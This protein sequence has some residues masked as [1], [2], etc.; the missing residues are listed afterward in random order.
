MSPDQP[1]SVA[2]YRTRGGAEPVVE[3]LREFPKEDR[4]HLGLALLRVQENWPV[5]MPLCKS[6]GSGLWEI[7]CSLSGNRIA[8]LIFCLQNNE[9]FVLHGFI[10]KTGK[11]P[12]A[13]LDL[14][15]ARMKEMTR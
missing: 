13:D 14:A 9:I 3:W 15:R 7:R 8:R 10:K 6:L 12:Q 2:F 1:L 11:I 5:G 4:R